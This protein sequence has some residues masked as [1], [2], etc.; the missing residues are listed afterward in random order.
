MAEVSYVMQISV[1]VCLFN[2]TNYNDR[3]GT[4]MSKWIY[5]VQLM[6]V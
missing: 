1:Y 5:E 3:K 2:K 4:K 6:G